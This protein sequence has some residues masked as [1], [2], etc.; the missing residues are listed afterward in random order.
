VGTIALTVGTNAGMGDAFPSDQVTILNSVSAQ[1][2][3]YVVQIFALFTI[4]LSQLMA[5]AFFLDATQGRS[6]LIACTALGSSIIGG[7]AIM[8]IVALF[9]CSP[10]A[11]YAVVGTA[12]GGGQCIN[13]TAFWSWAG[14][15]DILLNLCVMGLPFY[16]LLFVQIRWSMRIKVILPFLLRIL[17][18]AY[19]RAIER[20]LTICSLIPIIVFRLT[21]LS[22]STQT[23]LVPVF[24]PNNPTADPRTFATTPV[25]LPSSATFSAILP[26]LLLKNLSL[27]I[28]CIPFFKPFLQSVA[29][30]ALCN[31]LRT[32]AP[33]FSNAPASSTGKRTLGSSAATRSQNS[34]FALKG[35]NYS[36]STQNS[37]SG[38][39]V[40]KG[41][42][43]SDDERK[44]SFGNGLL[45]AVT[46]AHLKGDEHSSGH[47]GAGSRVELL[48]PKGSDLYIHAGEVRTE[49]ALEMMEIEKLSREIDDDMTVGERRDVRHLV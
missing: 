28:A 30:G 3:L 16:T 1:Q 32:F 5:V 22:Q 26:L 4:G 12:S 42:A 46:R 19:P 15:M 45:R 49:S 41:S 29:V 13:L 40:S 9:E 37:A 47:G 31:D 35:T 44:P 25:T 38:P 18:V 10:A 17:Y 20:I 43:Y 11:P 27:L 36:G 39:G 23:L 6:P 21:A 33:T 34:N 24:D 8:T 2:S 7:T 48:Q 14:V